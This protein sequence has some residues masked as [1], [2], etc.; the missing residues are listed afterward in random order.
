MSTYKKLS[1]L[2]TFGHLYYFAL[3]SLSSHSLNLNYVLFLPQVAPQ[4]SQEEQSI[5]P[6]SNQSAVKRVSFQEELTTVAI[7]TLLCVAM[8][9]AFDVK[10]SHNSET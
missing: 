1:E 3:G 8:N 10:H 7:V 9:A 2:H 5:G 4:L 6:F